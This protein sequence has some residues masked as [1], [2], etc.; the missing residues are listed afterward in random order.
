[1]KTDYDAK[2]ETIQE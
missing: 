2:I 1:M